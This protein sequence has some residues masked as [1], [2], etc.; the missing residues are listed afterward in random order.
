MADQQQQP[1]IATDA[2]IPRF[3]NDEDLETLANLGWP[4]ENPE[5]YEIVVAGDGSEHPGR[6]YVRN[7]YIF[8]FWVD[9]PK[10]HVAEAFNAQKRKRHLEQKRFAQRQL[11]LQNQGRIE[12]L[13]QIALAQQNATKK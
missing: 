9:D 2:H 6:H 13:Q 10:F 12:Q 1:H 8:L 5:D 3:A 11:I 4:M 7:G